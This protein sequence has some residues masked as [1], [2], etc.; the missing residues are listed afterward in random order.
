VI[1]ER[2]LVAVDGSPNGTDALVWATGLAD[3]LGA[4]V[5]AVHALGL[6]DRLGS[7]S[8]G[9]SQPR[10]EVIRRRFEGEWCA[11][12]DA[13]GVPA[14]KLLVDG[15]PAEVVLRVAEQEDVDLVVVGCRGHAAVPARLL[16][17]TSTA[18]AQGST[19]PVVVV[20]A[21]A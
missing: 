12:L 17:S 4:E 5:V 20:P 16:G 11:P 8:P 13:T 19:R 10:R 14:R 21:R 7:E 1:L 15:S 2:I 3:R 18:V 6:L 9:P